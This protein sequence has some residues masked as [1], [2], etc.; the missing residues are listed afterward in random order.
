MLVERLMRQC[1]QERR[2][3]TQLMHIRKEKEILRNN[4]YWHHVYCRSACLHVHVFTTEFLCT[5]QDRETETVSGGESE[6]V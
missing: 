1:L 4:R 3:A 6:R 5:C 2:I